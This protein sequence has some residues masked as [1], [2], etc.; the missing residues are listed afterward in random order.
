M[1]FQVGAPKSPHTEIRTVSLK[2]ISLVIQNCSCSESNLDE[3]RHMVRNGLI[4]FTPNQRA[5]WE[6]NKQQ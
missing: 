1:G 5:N 3:E 4:M 2:L 6:E